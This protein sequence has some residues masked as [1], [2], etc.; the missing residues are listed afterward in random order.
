MAINRISNCA[1][2]AFLLVL[3]IFFLPC[4]VKAQLPLETME[5]TLSRYNLYSRIFYQIESSK[6]SIEILAEERYLT[7]LI[8][9][10]N[11]ELTIRKDVEAA[12]LK[13]LSSAEISQEAYQEVE[14]SKANYYA[15]KYDLWKQYQILEMNLQIDRVL[16]LKRNLYQSGSELEKKRMF[17]YDLESAY[18]ALG[19]GENE[20]AIRLFDHLIGFYSHS[21]YDDLLFYRSEAYYSS[22]Q[23]NSAYLGYKKLITD[24]PASPYYQQSLFRLITMDFSRGEY[25]SSA[26]NIVR[27]DERY[28]DWNYNRPVLNFI[29]GALNYQFG[30]Y[31]QA[32]SYF[33]RIKPDK[34]YYYRGLYLQA[35]CYYLKGEYKEAMYILDKVLVGNKAKAYVYNES[36]IFEGDILLYENNPERAWGYYCLVPK[37]SGKYPRA[38]AGKA[39][40]HLMRGEYAA[41]DTIADAILAEYKNT[42][43][44]YLARCLK[45]RTARN[46]GQSETAAM[47]YER[48]LDESGK[49]IGLADFLMEKLKIVYILNELVDK[50]A[51]FLE[52]GDES[53]FN[54][55]WRLRVDT[56]RMLKRAMYTE[57][58]EVDG[59]FPGFIEEKLNVMRLL[60]EY[61]ALSEK[62]Q[63][64]E[65]VDLIDKYSAFLDTLSKVTSMVQIAG[66]GRVQN[67]PKYY[68]YTEN[69]FN[70]TRLDSLYRSVSAELSAVEEELSSA[71]EALTVVDSGI[72]P[73]ERAKMLSVVESIRSWRDE[74]DKK[75]SSTFNK[76]SATPE[77]DLTRWSHIA[78]HKS[79]VPGSD[80]NDLK[81]KQQ[82]IKD[83]DK[84]MQSLGLI[85]K[86]VLKNKPA[87]GQ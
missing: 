64:T 21:N 86:Q 27:F 71:A 56:E 74:L 79:M 13:S 68:R 12:S 29:A 34:R 55:Y 17:D 48:I 44:I 24:F 28:E 7:H 60:D 25:Q 57:I 65:D 83:I 14:S 38:L 11:Q 45:G 51:A 16:R 40:C 3:P 23:Y 36:A 80:Y 2:L 8:T 53:V 1:L 31:D 87:S 70:K 47:Q 46:L 49:K 35:H 72:M 61:S 5:D 59:E 26:E 10:I 62:A 39:V 6:F 58:S 33:Q 82:R 41:A 22:Q 20:L 75:M 67:L 77:L 63:K 78:F 52:A 32:L 37:T 76:L 85:T 81:A 43:Y 84:Y 4:I 9:G 42:E 50:E 18:S 73:M 19:G 30:N 15:R 66:Y 69:D 54:F